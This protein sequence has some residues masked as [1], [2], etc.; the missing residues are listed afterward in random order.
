MTDSRIKNTKRNIITGLIKQ[1]FNIVLPFVIQ[2]MIL[3]ILGEQYQGLNGLFTSVLLF[4]NLSELGFSLAVVY[5]LYKPI[6]DN[7]TEAICAIMAYLKKVYRI[8]GLAVL[9]LGAVLIPFLPLLIKGSYP[10]DINIYLLYII[11]LVNAVISYWLFAYKTAL[12]TA[13]Q[14]S[15][16]LNIISVVAK[17]VMYVFQMIV[18]LIFK[19]FYLFCILIPVFTIVNNLLTE[20]VSKRSFPE[21]T[22]KGQISETTKRELIRQVK[23]I[24]IGKVGDA[25]RNGAD[26]IVISAFLGLTAVAIYSNYYYIYLAVYS[27]SLVIVNSMGASVGNSMVKETKEKNYS[28]MCTF[29]FVFSWFTG[30]CAIC[31][32]CLYQDFM[33]IWMRG[34]TSLMLPDLDMILFC[35][36]FYAITMNNIRNQYVNG[37][38]LF[39]K[40]R[41]SNILEAVGN[42]ALNLILGYFWGITGILIATIVT[43]VIF[44]YIART[45]ILFR[46]YFK[47]PP[48]KF[49]LDN[50]LYVIVA[51][52][53]GALTYF[54]CSLIAV[55]GFAGL[56]IKAVICLVVPNILFIMLYFRTK[57]FGK[58][59][60]L[61]NKITGIKRAE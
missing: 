39:W 10:D 49:Y 57:Q 54:L 44:N 46:E 22:P 19:N 27:V 34:D 31:M 43:I 15:D 40:L 7:D 38:G 52:G 45:N 17:S 28:D 21:I 48:L 53:T 11:Y 4:L 42:I 8:I 25:T 14:R 9:A 24:F 32:L 5:I 1:L 58:A 2:T 20:Y 29:T 56:G 55:T 35:V 41:Y 18:L 51:A 26:N 47:T 37:C 59:R 61:M 33:F 16:L 6:A 23:G 60:V 3:Y 12:I 30:W 36:Y 13:M 50:V